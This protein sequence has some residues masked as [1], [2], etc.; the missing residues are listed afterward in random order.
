MRGLAIFAV[1]VGLVVAL[2]T[3]TLPTEDDQVLQT[4][5]EAQEDD[6]E[7]Q[8]NLHTLDH[9]TAAPICKANQYLNSG[10][11]CMNC[12]AGRI[13]PPGSTAMTSCICPANYY[14]DPTRNMQNVAPST[15]SMPRQLFF[16]TR[17]LRSE[18]LQMRAKSFQIRISMSS[19][20]EGHFC[21]LLRL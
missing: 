7:G 1:S 2:A 15:P 9:S 19:L 10:T 4:V 6:L 5:I 14:S 8:Q 16:T 3:G 11:W 20:P 18:G 21:L 13:S 12:P 17:I